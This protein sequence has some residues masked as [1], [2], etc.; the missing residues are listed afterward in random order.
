M[1]RIEYTVFLCFGKSALT[2]IIPF[3]FS[4]LKHFGKLFYSRASGFI[5]AIQYASGEIQM[6]M[7]SVCS[8][9]KWKEAVSSDLEENMKISN[10]E[11]EYAMQDS[12]K[13][14]E[15]TV[16]GSLKIIKNSGKKNM[17]G[18]SGIGSYTADR[19]GFVMELECSFDLS[20]E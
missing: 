15:G 11:V 14:S 7:K 13:F 9:L 12:R 6:T 8:V 19:N 16:N 10:A 1:N 17:R 3:R 5:L 18:I 4:G 20:A 2:G